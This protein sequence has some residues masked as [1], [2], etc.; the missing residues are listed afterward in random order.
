MA[1]AALRA[2][3]ECGAGG[4]LP[5]DQERVLRALRDA[6]CALA[7]ELHRAGVDWGAAAAHAADAKARKRQRRPAPAKLTGPTKRLRVQ[8]ARPPR[9]WS[10]AG[11]RWSPDKHTPQTARP[12]VP[13]MMNPITCIDLL[14]AECVQCSAQ[15]LSVL[16]FQD[17]HTDDTR[18]H[19][20]PGDGVMQYLFGGYD[21]IQRLCRSRASLRQQREAYSA[22]SADAAEFRARRSA[23]NSRLC[24]QISERIQTGAADSGERDFVVVVATDIADSSAS[25]WQETLMLLPF[26]GR[27]FV[28]DSDGAAEASAKVLLA[29]LR[30]FSVGGEAA[31]N[32]A[33]AL[34]GTSPEAGAVIGIAAQ[35]QEYSLDLLN[36]RLWRM[37]RW[38][39]EEWK[40]SRECT[41]RH[42]DIDQRAVRQVPA[43]HTAVLSHDVAAVMQAAAR[44]R[45]LLERDDR[46][47]MT[48]AHFA[49]AFRAPEE[50]VAAVSAADRVP[51]ARFHG[52]ADQWRSLQHYQCPAKASLLVYN[53]KS[54]S[55]EHW[56]PQDFTRECGALYTQQYV[57]GH[58]FLLEVLLQVFPCN[59]DTDRYRRLISAARQSSG[60][61]NLILSFLGEGV[62]HGAFARRAF[63]AGEYICTYIGEVVSEA[64][65]DETDD[66]SPG[67]YSMALPDAIDGVPVKFRIDGRR[68]RNLGGMINHSSLANAHTDA[69]VDRGTIVAVVC[70]ARPIAK[71]EQVCIDYDWQGADMWADMLDHPLG[72]FPRSLDVV[73]EP[74]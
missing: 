56:S 62:G 8:T 55:Y 14:S 42:L 20:A 38:A 37:L 30:H 32:A 45:G 11:G 66:P 60:D 53:R 2:A 73:S 72:T 16:R 29:G 18:L 57:C 65:V 40:A 24:D 25:P 36:R 17:D 23:A 12:R 13:T 71:Y 69:F 1:R 67:C 33:R 22:D 61:D 74:P 21:L 63:S 34:F 10:P 59:S 39:G 51:D 43:L 19:A 28:V 64:V 44:P 4:K 70:A 58:D 54:H 31:R 27:V 7:W 48:A 26:C 15:A 47:G 50:I 49:A 6:D 35:R 9:H 41:L 46:W 52:T 3:L 5:D 68:C